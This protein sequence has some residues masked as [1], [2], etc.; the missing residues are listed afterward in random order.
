VSIKFRKVASDDH[1]ASLLN[2]FFETAMVFCYSKQADTVTG[3]YYA[4][5][6]QKLHEEIKDKYHL[7][8]TNRRDT[9]HGKRAANKG[10]RPM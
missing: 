6:I 10:G 4:E 1:L 3:V 7:S 9:L 8:L 2:E 5:L